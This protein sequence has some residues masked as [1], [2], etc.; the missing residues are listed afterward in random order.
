M[1]NWKTFV[2]N[3][4]KKSIKIFLASLYAT[5]IIAMIAGGISAGIMTLLPPEDFGW[6]VSN[7]N[8][9]GYMS[10]CAFAPFSTLMLFAMALIGFI[11]LVKFAKYIRR[12][13]KNSEIYTKLKS[14]TNKVR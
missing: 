10:I 9:L 2:K 14:L 7:L 6:S 4:L 3:V 1:E 11:L 5:I 12:K 13:S 8:Y